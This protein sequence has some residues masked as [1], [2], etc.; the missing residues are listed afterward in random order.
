MHTTWSNGDVA[1]VCRNHPMSSVSLKEVLGNSSYPEKEFHRKPKNPR[2]LRIVLLVLQI[3]MRV[4]PL[5][6][7]EF[8]KF[9]DASSTSRKIAQYFDKLILIK[10]LPSFHH[11]IPR[12]LKTLYCRN[13]WRGSTS[14]RSNFLETTHSCSRRST[15]CDFAGYS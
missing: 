6:L 4:L 5:W 2:F 10:Y 1:Q 9:S 8:W 7:R 13:G 14:M 3:F 15:E 12:E 11:L